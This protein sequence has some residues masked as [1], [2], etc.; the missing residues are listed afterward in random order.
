MVNRALRKKITPDKNV[1][2]GN[3]FTGNATFPT[4]RASHDAVRP[5]SLTTP[6]VEA[7]TS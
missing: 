4:S 3:H 7:E 6:T 5:V 2:V 1:D